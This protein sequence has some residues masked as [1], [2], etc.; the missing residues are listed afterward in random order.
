VGTDN[1]LPHLLQCV[2]AY[3][4]VGEISDAMREA[5]GEFKE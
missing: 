2:E 1:L 4:S 5:W 3:A